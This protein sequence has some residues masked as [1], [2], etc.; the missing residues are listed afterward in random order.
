MKSKHQF[1]KKFWIILFTIILISCQNKAQETRNWTHF[2]RIAGHPLNIDNVNSIVSGATDSHVFGIE[3]DNDI[4]GRYGSFLDPTDKLEAIRLVSQKAHETANYTFVYIAGLECITDQADQKKHSFLKDHPDWVQKDISGR[5]A[6]FGG[7]DAFWIKEGDED[8]W[9]SPYAEDWRRLY[10]QRVREIAATGVDGVYV[11]IPYWMTHFEGWWDTWASF[12][13][14][15]VDAFMKRNGFNPK[16]EMRLGDITDPVFRQWVDFRIH[17]ITE[18]MQDID[19]NVK[20]VNPDCKTIAEIYPG[21]GEDA[22]RVGADVYQLYEVVDA[23]CHEYSEGAYMAA[24]REP[25]DWF[26]FMAGMYTF[27]A[28]AGQKSSWMLSYSWDG[29]D[30]VKPS[31]AMELLFLSQIMTGTNVWDAQGHVMS[32][33]NDIDT[34]K[35][36]F[37]W[38]QRWESL[39]YSPRTP[40]VPVGIYF[41]PKTRDY[42]SEDFMQAFMGT[43]QLI[44]QSH[45]EFQIVTPRTLSD[46]K[47][48]LLILPES[49][50]LSEEEAT[51]LKSLSSNGMGLLLTGQSGEFDLSGQKRQS[52]VL[53]SLPGFRQASPGKIVIYLED[54]PGS[55]YS[56]IINAEFNQAAWQ[57]EF[58]GSDFESARQEF[59]NLITTVLE[60]KPAVTVLASPFICSQ[61]AAVDG[62]VKIFLTNFKG[63][64]GNER[65]W[66]LPEKDIMINVTTSAGADVYF[67][68]YLGEKIKLTAIFDGQTL[69]VKI[70]ELGRGG[71]VLLEKQN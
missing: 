9:I 18:F 65:L 53:A 48:P 52:N 24:G 13:G 10:M 39:F 45:L 28:F 55:A 33:S 32:R 23:I 31:E 57:G 17:T 22:V 62:R 12:D 50:C 54:D 26:S 44:L 60:Y 14:Y 7:N 66:P 35:K 25:M 46:F 64:K 58:Q 40:I 19:K 27:R 5:P 6:I 38:I 29:E 37:K 36:V 2:V 71:V 51:I 15:T 1:F 69:D 49:R 43:M 47:G 59:V 8:V 68:P 30:T 56:V 16:T 20:A 61:I 70:P 41:S 3:V 63:V 42:F 34:R 11:D 21:L 67:L 4:T